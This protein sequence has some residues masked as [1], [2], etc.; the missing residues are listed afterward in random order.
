MRKSSFKGKIA[1]RFPHL[2]G[3]H[4][5]IVEQ[6][7]KQCMESLAYAINKYAR[8][9]RILYPRLP[10]LLGIPQS[11]LDSILEAKG[12][13]RLNDIIELAFAVGKKPVITF[14]DLNEKGE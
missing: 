8:D 2:K 11:R 1:D 14:E 12:N 3:A 13:P 4:E 5:R 10:S 7:R 9:N 6:H